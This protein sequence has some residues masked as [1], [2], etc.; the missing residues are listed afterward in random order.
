MHSKLTCSGICLATVF[1]AATLARAQSPSSA[2]EDK[3]KPLQNKTELSLQS[4]DDLV[5]QANAIHDKA[6]S[7]YLAQLRILATAE[8]QHDAACKQTDEVRRVAAVGEPVT[9]QKLGEKSAEKAVESA[10]AQQQAVRRAL[11]LTEVQKTLLGRTANA[12]DACQ[13]AAAALQNALDDLQAFAQEARLRVQDSSLAGNAAPDSLKE[14]YLHKL[15]NRLRDD[16]AV[17]K[18]K[19]A[20]TQRGQENV[21]RLQDDAGKAALACDAQAIEASKNLA[22]QRRRHDLEKAYAGK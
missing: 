7:D 16:L 10:R 5:K 15:T 3:N 22:R 1:L 14:E 4:N 17:L 11:K 8:A 2:T 13:T 20:E 18:R 12:I 19:A 21:A 6:L 9:P